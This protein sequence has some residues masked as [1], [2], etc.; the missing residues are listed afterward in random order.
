[1]KRLIEFSKNILKIKVFQN[2]SY[3]LFGNV[4]MQLL[5]LIA[6]MLIAKVFQP[7]LF[8][9]Y[10][11]MVVQSMLLAAIADL[12]HFSLHDALPIYRKS[13]V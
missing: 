8:G 11:F 13:V 2:F 1:M 7:E 3:L 4:G 12:V 10:S 5:N 9:I 6:V